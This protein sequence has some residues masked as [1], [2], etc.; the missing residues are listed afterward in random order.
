MPR[1]QATAYASDTSFVDPD[2]LYT[3]AGFIRATGISKSRLREARLMGLTLPSIKVGKRVY[4]KG[5]Q[6]ITFIEALAA[7]YAEGGAA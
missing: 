5:E 7:K 2:R 6:A 4:I 3:Q 1:E